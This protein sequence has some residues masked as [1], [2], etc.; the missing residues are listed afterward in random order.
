MITA[1]DV[2]PAAISLCLGLFG[3]YGLFYAVNKKKSKKTDEDVII[4][5]VN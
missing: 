1:L 5:K 4:S 3:G 2:V